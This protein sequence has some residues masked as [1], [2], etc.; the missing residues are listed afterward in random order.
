MNGHAK[1]TIDT[2]RALD[3]Q[4]D[5]DASS[6]GVSVYY[7]ANAPE[8]RVKVFAGISEIAA[9][10]VR[11]LAGEIA[12]LSSAGE[13]IPT[14]IAENA[15]IKR[16]SERAKKAAEAERLNRQREPFQRRADA[17]AARRRAAVEAAEQY[18]RERELRELM[19]PGS[20]R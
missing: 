2:L 15:R 18:S 5:E 17:E 8:R 4:F 16:Q 10:K 13:R 12:G 7:H 6:R 9:K 20:W 1:R 11:N 14:S 19:A 3:F